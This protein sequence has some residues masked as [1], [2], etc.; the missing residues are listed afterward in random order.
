[1]SVKAGELGIRA[2]SSKAKMIAYEEMI[3]DVAIAEHDYPS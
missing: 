1:M 2:H 3:R